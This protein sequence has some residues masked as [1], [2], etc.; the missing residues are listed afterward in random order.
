MVSFLFLLLAAPSL[1][2][3]VKVFAY[4]EGEKIMTKSYFSNG[5][6]VMHSPITVLNRSD[7]KTLLHGETNEEG[8]FEFPVPSAAKQQRMDLKIRVSTGEGHLAEWVLP[9]DEYLEQYGEGGHVEHTGAKDEVAVLSGGQSACDEQVVS[10]LVEQALDKK[11]APVK[12][13]IQQSRDSG[14]DFR[15]ILG[16]IGYIFGMAGIAAYM[17]SRKKKG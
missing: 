12:E 14:P 11:L 2:H 13:M 8:L 6:A 3:K 7:G 10:R 4:G 15:D 16:G 5:K 9:A 1:A 17:G